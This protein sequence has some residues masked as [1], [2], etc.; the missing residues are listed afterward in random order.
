MIEQGG[1]GQGF[2]T[3]FKGFVGQSHSLYLFMFAGL[4][5]CD[6]GVMGLEGLCTLEDDLL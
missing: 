5:R 2:L 6:Q 3:G 4:S 1:R